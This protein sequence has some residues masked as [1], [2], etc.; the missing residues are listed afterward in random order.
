MVP[1]RQANPTYSKKAS[2]EETHPSTDAHKDYHSHNDYNINN[3]TTHTNLRTFRGFSR[4]RD[5]HLSYTSLVSSAVLD[6]LQILVIP[7]GDGHGNDFRNLVLMIG[8]HMFS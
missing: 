8:F 4:M 1:P 3:A 7:A 6:P 5:Y 2:V